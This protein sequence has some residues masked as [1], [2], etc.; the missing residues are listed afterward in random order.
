VRGQLRDPCIDPDREELV[1]GGGCEGG[2]GRAFRWLCER[3]EYT[4]AQ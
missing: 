4:A 1:G 3:G 2:Q